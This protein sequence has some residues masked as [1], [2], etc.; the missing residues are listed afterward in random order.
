MWPCSWASH[1]TG[2]LNIFGHTT[3]YLVSGSSCILIFNNPS[4]TSIRGK[5]LSKRLNS[6]PLVSTSSG[7]GATPV[8]RLSLMTAMGDSGVCCNY[9]SSAVDTIGARDIAAGS[10]LLIGGTIIS[11]LDPGALRSVST[12]AEAISITM[13]GSRSVF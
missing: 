1:A 2:S 5:R 4:L 8:N 10:Q 3:F 9:S 7:S 12:A 13:L 6:S 11:V